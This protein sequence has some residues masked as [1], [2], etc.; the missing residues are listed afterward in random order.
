[1][2]KE[3]VISTILIQLTD[4]KNGSSIFDNQPLM[5]S[6][7]TFEQNIRND[8]EDMLEYSSDIDSFKSAVSEMSIS[9]LKKFHIYWNSLRYNN[10]MEKTLEDTKAIM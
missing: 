3:P 7:P 5:T 2:K 10:Q 6:Y 4:L 8:F 1:M 9:L